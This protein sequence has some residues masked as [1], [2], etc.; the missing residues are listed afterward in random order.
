MTCNEKFGQK[1][2]AKTRVEQAKAWTN[3][4][5]ID[6]SLLSSASRLST[7][8]REDFETLAEVLHVDSCGACFLN[9]STTATASTRNAAYTEL[10]TTCM[11]FATSSGQKLR[12]PKSLHPSPGPLTRTAPKLREFL[13]AVPI[14]CHPRRAQPILLKSELPM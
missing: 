9:R 8:L 11:S 3:A 2:R 7:P 5:S 12:G 4:T 10:C 6:E 14:V 1:C 13:R